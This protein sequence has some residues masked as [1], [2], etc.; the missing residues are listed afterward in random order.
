MRRLLSLGI[1]VLLAALFLIP[2]GTGCSKNA[3]KK[4][5]SAKNMDSMTDDMNESMV[6]KSDDKKADKKADK[7]DSSKEMTM[8]IEQLKFEDYDDLIAKHKGKVVVMDFWF[9]DCIPCEKSM[10]HLADMQKKYGEDKLI[11]MT[12]N[13]LDVKGDTRDNA[14]KFLKD[15]NIRLRHHILDD[16]ENGDIWEEKLKVS[17]FPTTI[18]YDTDGKQIAFFEGE[19]LE[20]VQKAVAKLIEKK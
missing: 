1:A 13:S 17:M 9:K 3:D 2:G 15:K 7:M 4:D 10:P 11:V 5:D 8:T 18:V 12:M 6:A 19:H 20:D 14:V 16:E